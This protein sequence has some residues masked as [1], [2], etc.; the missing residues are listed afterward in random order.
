MSVQ[1]TQLPFS[2]RLRVLAIAGSESRINLERFPVPSS[3]LA[4]HFH[5]E[6][7]FLFNRYMTTLWGK[8][9]LCRNCKQSALDEFGWCLAS[10]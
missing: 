5:F 4:A 9:E 1:T 7:E 8:F 10:N 6:I 2:C 3:N